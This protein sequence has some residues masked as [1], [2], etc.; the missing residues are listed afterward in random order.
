MRKKWKPCDKS[1][2]PLPTHLVR[3]FIAKKMRIQLLRSLHHPRNFQLNATIRIAEGKDT[4]LIAPTGSGKTL[5]LA[6]P[7]L[8]HNEKFS[9]VI[10]PLHALETDQVGKMNAMGMPSLL[11]DS[12]ELS[13]TTV[14]ARGT[15]YSSCILIDVIHS[16]KFLRGSIG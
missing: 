16:R 2:Q 4:I 11:V 5:V 15:R 14:R 9:L 13:R 10:S 8:F 6:M 3:A 1:Q 12:V 7:L